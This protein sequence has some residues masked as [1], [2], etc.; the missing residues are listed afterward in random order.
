[1]TTKIFINGFGR[2]GRLVLRALSEYNRTSEFQVMGIN[3]P[4][5]SQSAYYLYKY[6]SVHG[7]AHKPVTYGEDWLNVGFGKIPL[8]SSRDPSVFDLSKVDIVLECTGVYKTRQDMQVFFTVG[9]SK[10]LVS[11]P[12]KPADCT[13][14]Y[15]VN[16][17]DITPDKTLVSNASCT[18]NC[19]APVVKVLDRAFGID[20]G[21]MTTIHAYTSD[22]Q[23]LDGSHKYN[24]RARAA[25][26]SI[27]PTSSGAARAIKEV[28]PHMEGKL[29]GVAMRVPT[30][31]VSCI[32]FKV[33]LQQ[34]VTVDTVNTVMK[35][36]AQGDMKG[37]LGYETDEL[38]SVDFNHNP[39]SSIFD[40]TQT[41][42]MQGTSL[43]VVAWY[44]NEWG[45]S[46]RMLDTAKYM[47][48]VS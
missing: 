8:L 31:N 11:A 5:G 15:G 22:Q 34:S 16:H 28:M 36:S 7:I 42:V 27:V 32:D 19:L 29:D 12:F 33:D 45:F 13:V 10:I 2:I 43:R 18:T 41:M 1:M 6:D 39:H 35:Q 9:A 4:R 20:R 47:H 14:V 17:T 46:C 21:Y 44:D 37:I 26:L 24:R 48:K 23:V 25:G 40:A 3:H 30:P 38:V